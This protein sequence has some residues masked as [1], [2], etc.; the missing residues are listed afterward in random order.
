MVVVWRLVVSVEIVIMQSLLYRIYRHTC[1]RNTYSTGHNGILS[2][3][4]TAYDVSV[5]LQ[6]GNSVLDKN[7]K[8]PHPTSQ[9]PG[10]SCVWCFT[11]TS[12]CL[13][14]S[15]VVCYLSGLNERGVELPA[16]SGV[17]SYKDR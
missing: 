14:A 6:R 1:S 4:N 7:V 10:V 3:E 12:L 11:V 17:T 15:A 2:Y 8:S 13:P 5:T 9:N 16:G